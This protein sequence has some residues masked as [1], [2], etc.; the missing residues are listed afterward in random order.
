M[1]ITNKLNLP[2]MVVQAVANERNYDDKTYSVTEILNPVRQI[3]LSRRYKDSLVEDAS[4]RIFALLG[5]ATHYIVEQY[6]SDKALSEERIK[7]TFDN[8][9]SVTGAFDIYEDK[10]LFDLKTTSVWSKVYRSGY[11]KW[12]QQLNI[13]RYLLVKQGFEVDALKIVAI[14]RDW[15]VGQA[16]RGGDYPPNQVEVI[17]FPIWEYSKVEEFIKFQLEEIDSYIRFSDDE[18][19]LCSMEDRWATPTKYAIKKKGRKSAVK[20]FDDIE[21]ATEYL[22]EKKDNK[23]SLETR[24]GTDKKCV[25]YCSCNKYCDYYQ[26]RYGVE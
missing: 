14:Y 21:R 20:V 24:V 8:G 19:P 10:T 4:D 5:T 23:L 2:E 9:Y 6:E 13:Y 17:E 15:S 12:E 11:D 7:Y 22:R 3:L 1:K 25:S 18:L 26:E 16:K